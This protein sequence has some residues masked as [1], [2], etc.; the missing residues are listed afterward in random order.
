MATNIEIINVGP[1]T[2][3]GAETTSTK[4]TELTEF[5]PCTV[6]P[7]RTNCQ[8]YFTAADHDFIDTIEVLC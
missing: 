7:P 4:Q 2:I 1:K 6:R 8:N 5:I 3:Q